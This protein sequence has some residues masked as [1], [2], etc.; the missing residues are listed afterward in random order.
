L[1]TAEPTFAASV[2]AHLSAAIAAREAATVSTSHLATAVASVG[3]TLR[4]GK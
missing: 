2:T 4:E 1:T 3:A